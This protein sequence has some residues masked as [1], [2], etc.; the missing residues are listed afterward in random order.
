MLI[1]HKKG[2]QR[3]IETHKQKTRIQAH[4]KITDSVTQGFYFTA[5]LKYVPRDSDSDHD[6][7]GQRFFSGPE[8]GIGCSYSCRMCC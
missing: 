3:M 5:L 4:H 7:C 2:E 1:W 6:F 8:G